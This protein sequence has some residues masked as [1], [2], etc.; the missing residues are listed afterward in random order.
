MTESR[1]PHARF[2]PRPRWAWAWIAVVIVLGAVLAMTLRGER[3]DSDVLSLLPKTEMSRTQSEAIEHFSGTFS[4]QVLWLI[5]ADSAH[6]KDFA[7]G[8]A[9]TG[10]FTQITGEIS[11]AEAA[12]TLEEASRMS[13]ALLAP[14]AIERLQDPKKLAQRV[15]AALYAP[16]AAPS[17]GE[18]TRD[19]ALLLRS[20][21]L[22]SQSLLPL[23]VKDGWLTLAA[24]DGTPWR[25]ISAQLRSECVHGERSTAV[26]TQIA[27]LEE[28]LSASGIAF[29]HQGA[30]FHSVA[31]AATAQHDINTLGYISIAALFALL[32]IAF[33]SLR[34][35]ILATLSIVA[36]AIVGLTATLALFGSVHIITLVMCLSLIGL[37]ADYT[38]YY[39]ARRRTEGANESPLESLLVLRPALLHAVLSTVAAYALM[40]LAP[41]PG[42]RQLAVFAACGLTASWLTVYLLFPFLVK[43][44]AARRT[45]P[46]AQLA[47]VVS[48]WRARHPIV[49]ALSASL[50]ALTLYGLSRANYNDDL[51]MLQS[52][53]ETLVAHEKGFAALLGQNLSQ[54][55]FIVHG[56][57]AEVVLTRAM[58]LALALDSPKVSA[59]YGRLLYNLPLPEARQEQV[60]AQVKAA[61]PM[62]EATLADAAGIHLQNPQLPSVVSFTEW[63]QSVFGARAAGLLYEHSDGSLSALL[64]VSGVKDAATLEKLANHPGITWL[65]RR[66][67]IEETF[68][69]TRIT[70]LALLALS[71]G[72]VLVS[73]VRKF[74]VARGT[75]GALV[76]ALSMAAGLSATTLVGIPV[77]LFSLFALIL[78]LGI[79]ID[80]VVFFL[81]FERDAEATLRAMLTALLTTLAS[82]GIL[83]LSATEAVANFGWVLSA[84]VL[85]AF[86]LAP[87]P[88]LWRIDRD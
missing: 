66:A 41:F 77:N 6:A 51:R 5:N 1:I 59:A 68:H 26:V 52:P 10:A 82:L 62:I 55:G 64:T 8:L 4:T 49:L 39:L 33:R 83:T 61:L 25:F 40:A 38:T 46:A 79:S 74:G 22:S 60:R 37:C 75:L 69:H 32:F 70:L 14:S 45:P 19:P 65:N 88:L 56:E 20:S 78:I 11:A 9:A 84:G 3:I 12:K 71:W 23:T 85:V 76:V 54:T 81:S 35:L 73:L 67:A 16:L 50:I 58:T 80:Y 47:R 18:L 72:A 24:A 29:F 57:S 30:L 87:M 2:L 42:L 31:A 48:L 86:L 21:R 43:G 7:K 44:F 63:R 34:P 13:A 15:L 53:P 27:A 36:G 17:L 28:R